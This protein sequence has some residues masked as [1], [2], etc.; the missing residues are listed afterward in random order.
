MLVFLHSLRLF[1]PHHPAESIA[2]FRP[3]R[4]G[5]QEEE[6]V[7][8][9]ARGQQ[10]KKRKEKKWRAKEFNVLIKINYEIVDS[11]LVTS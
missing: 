2:S 5:H 9:E 3:T 11:W 8:D 1:I 6:E 7:E 4:T 10:Q